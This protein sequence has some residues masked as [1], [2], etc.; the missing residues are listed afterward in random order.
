MPS[1]HTIRLMRASCA[2]GLLATSVQLSFD[3]FDFTTCQGSSPRNS[4]YCCH[5]GRPGVTWWTQAVGRSPR[6]PRSPLEVLGRAWPRQ[7]RGQTAFDWPCW[8]KGGLSSMDTYQ[9][10]WSRIWSN[11]DPDLSQLKMSEH[12]RSNTSSLMA[13]LR[14]TGDTAWGPV[15]QWPSLDDRFKNLGLLC[16]RTSSRQDVVEFCLEL[17]LSETSWNQLKCWWQGLTHNW[18]V[19]WTPWNDMVFHH[20]D[21]LQDDAN[22]VDANLA[23]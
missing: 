10:K 18:Y 11:M 14:R 17:K 4:K 5:R 8:D 6:S 12:R 16:P 20:P 3:H 7:R 15:H 23:S 13:T 21:G 1:L 9:E 19:S 2:A 22:C